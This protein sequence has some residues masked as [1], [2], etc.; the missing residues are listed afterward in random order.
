MFCLNYNYNKST[1]TGKNV[2]Q[3]ST[4]NENQK[5][6]KQ[7]VRFELVSTCHEVWSN[8]YFGITY[9]KRLS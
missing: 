4:H 8:L 1:V 6:E 3:Q 5:S 7:R 2:L 9:F